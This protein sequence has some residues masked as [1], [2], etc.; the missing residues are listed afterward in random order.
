MLPLYLNPLYKHPALF[1]PC[2]HLWL[3]SWCVK[4]LPAVR[5]T[6]TVWMYHLTMALG[7][8]NSE[9]DDRC[10]AVS[11]TDQQWKTEFLVLDCI[12]RC[13]S[14]EWLRCTQVWND[15]RM[16]PLNWVTACDA[17]T[18][19][20]NSYCMRVSACQGGGNSWCDDDKRDGNS[21]SDTPLEA[22]RTLTTWREGCLTWKRNLCPQL[23]FLWFDSVTSCVDCSVIADSQKRLSWARINLYVNTFISVMPGLQGCC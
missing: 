6:A 14:L 20:G 11:F 8:A 12:E 21:F 16:Q 15:E 13:V 2:Y 7:V 10:N 22:Q 19:H 3:S 5:E 1:I 9:T 4:V 18:A 17:A 23:N